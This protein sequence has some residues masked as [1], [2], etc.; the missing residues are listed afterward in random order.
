MCGPSA[1]QGATSGCG[2]CPQ[3]IA[4]GCGGGQLA[5]SGES[6]VSGS[7]HSLPDE[8][9]APLSYLS[10]AK[11]WDTLNLTPERLASTIAHEGVKKW[12]QDR[13]KDRRQEDRHSWSAM[14]DFGPTGNDPK[15]TDSWKLKRKWWNA[16]GKDL[17]VKL[18]SRYT[19]TVLE[20]IGE[21]IKDV[22]GT[23]LKYVPPQLLAA[24]PLV[25]PVLA[26]ALVA[27]NVAAKAGLGEKLSVTDIAGAVIKA[28][29]MPGGLPDIVGLAAKTGVPID[30]I[31]GELGS[32]ASK[33]MMGAQNGDPLHLAT[34]ADLVKKAGAGD[35]A[36]KQM[37]NLFQALKAPVEV[38]T[39]AA[40]HAPVHPQAP[41]AAPAPKPAP[42][43]AP[44]LTDYAAMLR[45][46]V[47]GQAL[48]TAG[49]PHGGGHH[50]GGHH[51]GGHRPAGHRHAAPAYRG[52]A[53]DVWPAPTL[54]EQ[55]VVYV[56]ETEPQPEPQPQEPLALDV[57]DDPTAIAGLVQQHA[58]D[59][60]FDFAL[61]YARG[62]IAGSRV[63]IEE[64]CKIIDNAKAGHAAS[65]S[66]LRYWPLAVK[67][68][69]LERG[70]VSGATARSRPPAVHYAPVPRA[71]H[72]P[73]KP[74]MIHAGRAAMSRR[75]LHL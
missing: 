55:P 13:G 58:H 33:I 74:S 16:A 23:I 12:W 53:W 62:I 47:S 27:I 19:T 1:N 28:A 5:V 4:S 31:A 40:V 73:Q 65:L 35:L 8:I 24:V 26:P 20:D 44:T 15:D 45:Q 64:V 9:I 7:R 2:G 54:V 72:A 3:R 18:R 30:K 22:T 67:Q 50:G 60:T 25:G 17:R 14:K 52:G 70:A 59:A 36:S 69:R 21:G 29:G 61:A 56:L 10:H 49:A 57:P 37:L 75:N 42:A 41:A 34:V 39:K 48:V 46:A 71:A 51:G 43:P 6:V 11:N 32:T 38:A 63:H 68:A 66:F